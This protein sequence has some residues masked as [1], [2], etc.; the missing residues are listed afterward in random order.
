MIQEITAKELSLRLE[1][2]EP[3]VLVDVR[4]PWEFEFGAIAGSKLIPLNE[5]AQRVGEIEAP[6]GAMIVT[7]CHHGVRSMHAAIFLARS[8]LENVCSLAGG[9]DAWSVDVDP[10]LPRY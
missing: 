7:V 1:R 6:S 5:L 4:Q 3:T 9:T 10:A 8:G 2:G